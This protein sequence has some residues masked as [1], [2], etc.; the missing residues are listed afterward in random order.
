LLITVV[1][2]PPEVAALKDDHTEDALLLKQ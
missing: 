2:A 1:N